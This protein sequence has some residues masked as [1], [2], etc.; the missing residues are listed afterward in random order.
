MLVSRRYR[1]NWGYQIQQERREPI[2]QQYI[3][4]PNHNIFY[5]DG[6]NTRMT[7]DTLTHD[8]IQLNN[9]TA[10]NIIKHKYPGYKPGSAED[11]SNENVL[12][13]INVDLNMSGQRGTGVASRVRSIITAP[14]SAGVRAYTSGAAN[15]VRNTFGS[16]KYRKSKEWRP[17]FKGELH[18]SGHSFCGPGTNIDARL[19][20]GD[21]GLNQ[22]DRACKVH[23][24]DYALAKTPGDV[25]SAD[26]NFMS[27]INKAKGS[28][29]HKRLIKAIF[30]RKMRMEDKGRLSHGKFAYESKNQSKMDASTLQ[31]HRDSTQ[32]QIGVS[33]SGEIIGEASTGIA[34]MVKR[35]RKKDPARKLRKKMKKF[36]KG[37][38]K[39][40]KALRAALRRIRSR[41]I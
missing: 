12:K 11:V 18:L 38:R 1:N 23:D 8:D 39:T 25:R 34:K 40:N 2:Y 27:N 36:K 21:P 24:I 5:Y 9:S 28:A 15:Q 35:R 10:Q 30:K 32:A 6:Y 22:L 41:I 7:F 20:R 4:R 14:I 16:L 17:G 37:P 31:G 26:K 13:K 33:G 29:G 3:Q 19:K